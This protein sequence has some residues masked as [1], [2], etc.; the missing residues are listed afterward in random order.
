MDHITIYH[1]FCFEWDVYYEEALNVSSKKRELNGRKGLKFEQIKIQKPCMFN[2]SYQ[3]KPVTQK[4][5]TKQKKH[6]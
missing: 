4:N 5:K 3:R 6:R 2:I 1:T